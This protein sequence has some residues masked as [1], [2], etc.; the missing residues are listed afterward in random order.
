VAAIPAVARAAGNPV[1]ANCNASGRLTHHYTLS[2]LQ[3]AYAT[4]PVDSREYSSCAQ[5]IENQIQAQL[6]VL[7]VKGHP[8]NSSGGVST[9]TIVIIVVVVLILLGG[10]GLALRAYRH[11]DPGAGDGA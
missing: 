11:R 8:H 9:A 4:I 10:G 6:S 7:K 3:Q 2:Q 1:I 5:V